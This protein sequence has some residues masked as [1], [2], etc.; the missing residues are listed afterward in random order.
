MIATQRGSKLRSFVSRELLEA[1]EAD[2]ASLTL[3]R[4]MATAECSES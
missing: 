4:Y 2:L 3:A 1:V